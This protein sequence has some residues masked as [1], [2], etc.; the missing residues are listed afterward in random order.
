MAFYETLAR[1][2]TDPI[3]GLL[4]LAGKDTSTNKLTAI[5]GSAADDA[6]NLIIPESVTETAKELAAKGI[7]MEYA[8]S[9]GLA[10]LAELM[11]LE[12]IGQKTCEEL[13]NSGVHR[14]EIVSSAG[15]NA[16]ATTLLACTNHDDEIITHNPHWAGYDSIV[17]GIDRKP[18]V[19]FD[20]LDKD[21]NFNFADFDASIKQ[22]I[23]RNPK[24]KITILLNTPYDNPLGK[25]FGNAVWDRLAEILAKYSSNEILLVIDTAYIDFGPS[26]KDYRRLSFL[27]SL[28]QKINNP[29]FNVVIAATVSKSFA[30]YGARVG[31]ATLLTTNKQNA[32]NWRDIAGGCIRGTFSNASR[33]GQEIALEILKNP[34]KLACV[35]QFQ[36]DTSK[37]ITKRR[38]V[39]LDLISAKLPEE[40]KLIKPDS[41]FFVSLKVST[42]KYQDTT[43][44]NALYE[45]VLASQL[46]VPMI[47]SQFLRIP[48]CGLN[49][50]KLTQVIERLAQVA[51]S[52]TANIK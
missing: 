3:V 40:F 31:V 35:H 52:M 20:I 32:D 10:G 5:I 15:T 41:G 21:D 25:D 28:F 38:E 36:E 43:Y 26:G 51:H 44:A 2:S 47:S 45:K 13:S 22:I 14:A 50:S 9:T 37:L 24:T 46:Y 19:N 27:P 6:G 16:I 7:N 12:F 39:L 29:N 8:P 34:A 33:F 23:S 42:H 4:Q 30:M 18:L 17:L 11:S 49:E 48:V 1:I